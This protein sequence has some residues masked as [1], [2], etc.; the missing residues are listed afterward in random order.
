MSKN[1]GQSDIRLRG[2][3][4][5]AQ[6]GDSAAYD[7]LL[8]EV[9]PI[10]RGL[11]RRRGYFLATEDT[12][13]LAQDVLLSIH[14]VRATYDPGRPFLPWMFAIMSN[15]L[16]DQARKKIR[17]AQNEI[18]VENYEETFSST[19]SHLDMEAYGDAEA[20]RKAIG[21]LPVGQRRAVELMKIGE[22]SLKEASLHTGIS[23]AALK[24]AVHRGIIALRKTL[25]RPNDG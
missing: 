15:R 13:D 19:Q 17:V 7:A 24:V 9:S 4:A 20:L 1:S 12:E 8:R 21:A 5:A 2:L 18:A 16:A 6:D 11:I 25:K 23:V 14:A 3:M 22:M 10:I